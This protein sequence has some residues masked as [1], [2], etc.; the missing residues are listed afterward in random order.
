MSDIL[1]S[2][3]LSSG[4]GV[5]QTSPSAS[6]RRSP[7]D[8]P[9]PSPPSEACAGQPARGPFS[10]AA[11]SPGT[12]SRPVGSDHMA[13]RRREFRARQCLL[14]KLSIASRAQERRKRASKSEQCAISSISELTGTNR[15]PQNRQHQTDK[16]KGQSETSLVRHCRHISIIDSRKWSSRPKGLV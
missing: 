13:R 9:V 15:Q 7:N 1:S 5:G 16:T 11:S 3:I 2:A 12:K 14:I 4:S 8:R 6:A 10:R